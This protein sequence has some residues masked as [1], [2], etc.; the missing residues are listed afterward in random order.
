MT[1]LAIRT[2][3]EI[4]LPVARWL[5]VAWPDGLDEVESILIEGPVRVR[6]GRVWLRGHASTRLQAG[7]AYASEFLV[8]FGPL[9]T[10]R[11]LE[12][13]VDGLGVS[14]IGGET[15]TGADINLGGF[16][17]LW[18]QSIL[19]PTCW[20]RLPGLRWTAIDDTEVLVALPY[21]AGSVT[22]TLRFDPDQSSFPVAFEAERSRVPGGPTVSWRVELGEWHWREGLAL[23]TRL[24]VTW[25]GDPAPWL[26]LRV[27]TV[28]PN[29][30]VRDDIQ[31][32]AETA[33]G[34]RA[35]T[36]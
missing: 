25:A 24:Q 7:E 21:R 10:V 31:A 6:R 27:E 19:F 23:P 36:R 18:A 2:S 17:A 8:G 33:G 11:G 5:E 1:M 4:P 14:T 26:D 15:A 20:T 9:T 34:R 13:Y 12:A 3:A 35:S 16:L 22:A 29:A 30:H 28:V 32:A